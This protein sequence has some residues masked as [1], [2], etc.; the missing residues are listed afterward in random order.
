MVS[1]I[2]QSYIKFQKYF[3][4]DYRF[5]TTLKL[6]GSVT[7]RIVHFRIVTFRIVH[8]RIVT[9]RLGNI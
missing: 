3:K 5:L 8:F 1:I 9:F 2:L 6:K 4:F 7:F